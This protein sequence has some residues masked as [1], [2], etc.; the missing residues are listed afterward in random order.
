MGQRKN[1]TASRA[2]TAQPAQPVQPVQVI[3]NM[4]MKYLIYN[5]DAVDLRKTSHGFF[6][7][8]GDG[9]VGIF[10]NDT[11][12]SALVGGM[13]ARCFPDARM[14]D[15]ESTVVGGQVIFESPDMPVDDDIG[16]LVVVADGATYHRMLA[17][18]NLDPSSCIVVTETPV[19]SNDF[20]TTITSGSSRVV[21]SVACPNVQ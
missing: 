13:I 5:D 15:H 12:T 4:V 18:H 19:S 9:T 7:K 1:K 6:V 3:R 21:G 11:P 8:A 2:Q 14:L 20:T 16:L 17:R 10:S